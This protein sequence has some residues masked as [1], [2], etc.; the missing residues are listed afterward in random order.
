MKPNLERINYEMDRQKLTVRE[1][2]NL[3][4]ISHQLIY[5]LKSG[6]ENTSLATLDAI[7]KALNI[8][9]KDLII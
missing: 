5:E 3:S 1:L 8:E 7:A 6:K 2:A 4:G 9:P